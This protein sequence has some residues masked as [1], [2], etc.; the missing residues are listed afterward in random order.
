MEEVR[1]DRCNKLL[2]KIRG[3]YQIKCTRC[4]NIKEGENTTKESVENVSKV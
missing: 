2:G 4:D 1:C 3:Q